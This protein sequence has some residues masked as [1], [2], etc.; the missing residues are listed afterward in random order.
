MDD[1]HYPELISA[2]RN[3]AAYDHPAGPIEIRETH[4]SWVLLTDPFAYKIKK[5]VDFGFLDFSTLD[6]RRLFCEAE[7]RLNRRFAADLYLAVV[8]IAGDPQNPRIN[9]TGT[10]IEFA[11]KMRRFDEAALFDRLCQ[12]DR[13]SPEHVDKLAE[14]LAQF[15][16]SIDRSTAE[17]AHG[18]PENIYGAAEQNFIHIGPLRDDPVDAAKLEAVRA[19]TSESYSRCRETMLA[20]KTADFVRECHGDLHLGNIVL[21]DDRPTPFDC[22]EFNEDLRWIDVMSE[23]AFLVMDLEVKGKRDLA[24]RFLNRYLELTGDYGGLGLLDYY[25]VYRAMVRAKI[26]QLTR[27]STGDTAKQRELLA[28]YRRYIDYASS[29]IQPQKPALLI[30]H[31]FS[32]SGKSYIAG[33][34]AERLPAIRLRSDLERKRLAGF[35]EHANTGST[36]DAGIYTADM[37]RRTYRYL[38]DTAEDI[39]KSGLSVIVDAAF[40]KLDQRATHRTLAE[41]IGAA[42]LILDCQAPIAT[43]KSRIEARAQ[44][45]KDP[46]E[47][48]LKVLENQIAAHDALTEEERRDTLTIDTSGPV[49]FDELLKKIYLSTGKSPG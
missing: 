11:I 42:F 13:L 35:D 30:T 41:R 5:P 46:S 37:T 28:L 12:D 40:L 6:K 10:S 33:Q 43:L 45:G 32:G 34:I 17:D 39:L 4:I 7:L 19:W 23:L 1:A 36:L 31:G 15:H 21:I 47:A 3:P 49:S 14:L 38:L 26:A 2:L 16:A 27:A 20:R 9:G 8:P 29:L 44:L 24:F 22:I 25:R 48:N 18:L